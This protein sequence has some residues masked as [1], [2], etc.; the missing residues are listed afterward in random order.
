MLPNRSYE[1]FRQD[2]MELSEA[3]AEAIRKLYKGE[4]SRPRWWMIP[5]AILAGAIIAV[6]GAVIWLL[7]V[8]WLSL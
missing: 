5:R 2:E 3:H 7:V 1:Q 4:Y 8:L 6:A